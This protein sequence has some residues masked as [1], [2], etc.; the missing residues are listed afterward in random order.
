MLSLPFFLL[1][2]AAV[3]VYWLIPRQRYRTAFLSL[4]SLIFI[5]LADPRAALMVLALSAYAYGMGA[6]IGSTHRALFHRLGVAG[7]LCV[8]LLFKYAGLLNETLDDLSG[9]FGSFP[10]FRFDRLLLPLGI[11]YITLKYISYLTDIHWR[12]VR[13]G[14][15]VEVLCY[16]SLFTIF[17][18]GPI[19]R[20]ERLAP[21]LAEP[22]ARFSEVLLESGMRRIAF[23]LFKK[24]VIAD[25]IG[26]LI[27]PLWKEGAP[28]TPA[29]PML[30]LLGFSI[31]IYLDFAG[32][33]DIA[34]G[35]SRLFGLTIME[36]FDW[37]YLQS[38][39]SQF[40][41]HWHISLSDWIRDYLFF[42]LSR[43]SR[44]RAWT[45]VAVPLIAMGLCGLWHGPAWHFVVWGMWHG[46]GIAALQVWNAYVRAHPAVRA[47]TL[48]RAY[49]GAAVLVTFTFVTVGWIWFRA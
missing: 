22:G 10:S 32:Y 34:I 20:F 38:D 42:P 12:V 28:G 19:E 17:S 37:P 5:A 3:P 40:W 8:L 36:N 25:W 18:A 9:L 2:V 33:S 45:M 1:L 29:L 43:V 24:L 11:S 26:Y 31:Q 4:V 21:Q 23:G 49:H 30:A 35:A 44:A 39:I 47:F 46:A 41:R 14:G 27:T 7:I 6:L 13:P 15:P 16:G 48:G